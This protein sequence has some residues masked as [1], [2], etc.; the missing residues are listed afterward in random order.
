[1]T[2]P[3]PEQ[4][5]NAFG[6]GPLISGWEHVTQELMDQFA[7]ATLD[8]DWMHIDPRRAAEEGPFEGTIAFG[9]WT[10]ALLTYFLRDAL[11][12]EYPEGVRYGFN[13]GLDRV[14]FVRPL[15]VGSRIRNRM[16]I[17]NIH[18][19]GNGRFLVTTRNTVE[20]GDQV[21]PAMVAD[22]LLMLV[23]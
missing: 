12:R 20:V 23:Y 11:G 3:T 4:V 17:A 10:L 21:E 1:M 16:E 7:L 13:Y 5:R 19:R 2:Y 9:F 15:P 14:R 22:W 18:D 6:N 8:P